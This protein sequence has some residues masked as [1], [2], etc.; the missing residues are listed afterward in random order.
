MDDEEHLRELLTGWIETLESCT[1]LQAKD[2]E[3]ALEMARRHRP[4]A[5]V[6]DAVMPHMSG[7]DVCATLK[8]DPDL[9]DIPVLFLS[10]Q[11]EIQD[12]VGGLEMGAHAYITKP[13]KPQELLARLRSVLR[14][15][16]RQDELKERL[17]RCTSALDSLP[18]GLAVLNDQG[19][20]ETWNHMLE[21]RTGYAAAEALGKAPGEL[22]DPMAMNGGPDFLALGPEG[23][24]YRLTGRKG[25]LQARVIRHPAGPGSTLLFSFEQQ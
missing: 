17:G 16:H 10:V 15:K 11:N 24:S 21:E 4:D 6:L 9:C 7:F 22:L 25:S 12:I 13:F 14:L 2:G 19:C 5:I 1:V 23:A 20:I 18:I 8:S 3:E